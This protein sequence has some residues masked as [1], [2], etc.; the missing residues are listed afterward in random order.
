MTVSPSEATDAAAGEEPAVAPGIRR[1]LLTKKV[2]RELRLQLLAYR[3]P[4]SVEF[5]LV[6]QRYSNG[7]VV[8]RLGRP[9][10]PDGGELILGAYNTGRQS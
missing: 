4:F 8:V 1:I 3:S 6:E 7:D 5:E 2:L 10:K 9:D